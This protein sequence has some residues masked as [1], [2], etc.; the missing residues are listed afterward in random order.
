M[1]SRGE[2]MRS[3]L[4]GAVRSWGALG[5]C[6]FALGV[7]CA[8]AQKPTPRALPPAT[9]S[10]IATTAAQTGPSGIAPPKLVLVVVVDG[11]PQEQLLKN[12]DLFVPNGFRRLMDRGARFVDAHQAHAVTVTAVGHAAVLTGAY[13]YQHGIIGNEWRLRDGKVMYCVADEAHKYLDGSPTME[14]D[15]TSPR[16]L[17]ASTVG[18]ELRYSNNNLSKV[19]AVSA[20]DRGS[21][22]LTG[23][24][25]TAYMY[26]TQTGNFSSTSYYMEKH[27]AWVESY[28]AAKPQDKYFKKSWE[29]LLDAKAYAR[30]TPDGQSYATS[31]RQLPTR[32]GLQYG[33]AME[34][35]NSIYYQQLLGG[36][37]AD[38][39]LADFSL[40]LIRNES[41]GRNPAGVPDLFGVSFSSHDYI[42]HYFGPTSIQSQDH[43]LRLDR[44]LAKMF[45]DI[46][47][48]VGRDNVL[49]VLTADH[50]FMDVPEFSK[51]RNFEAARID[52]A[53]MRNAVN[54]E[55]ERQFSVPKLVK[56]TVTGGATLDYEAAAAKGVSRDALERAAQRAF[57][58]FPGIGFAYTRSQLESGQLPQTHLSKLFSR[59]WDPSSAIDIFVMQKPFHYFMSRTTKTPTACSHGTPYTYDTNVPLIFEGARWIKQGRYTQTSAV[60]DIAPTLS[61]ILNLRPPSASEGRVLGEALKMQLSAH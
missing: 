58:A 56:Q 42:N 55:L 4:L 46:D 60:V 30:S 51:S 3:F 59:S 10:T 41:L 7:T 24:T 1:F 27:P 6:V 5:L 12:Y 35:P 48:L 39:M 50:G 36:P 34:A 22:L 25:G 40:A 23:K 19:F 8:N 38:E 28:N 43:L 9:S 49:T 47:R 54:A 37:F 11:L 45:D 61:A 17:R 2:M 16:N 31:F 29:P 53:D 15:G 26:M 32:F 14:D 18:D 44:T 57:L 21:I 52:A 20:K 33:L 13:P